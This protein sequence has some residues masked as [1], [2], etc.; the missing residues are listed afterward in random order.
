[1]LK[2]LS[3][4]KLNQGLP[5]QRLQLCPFINCY[6]QKYRVKLVSNRRDLS[7]PLCVVLKNFSGYIILC[8]WTDIFHSSES[9][10][11]WNLFISQVLSCYFNVEHSLSSAATVSTAHL[12]P[13]SNLYW[14]LAWG[15]NPFPGSLTGKATLNQLINTT[16]FTEYR[17]LCSKNPLS[18]ARDIKAWMSVSSWWFHLSFFKYLS[19]NLSNCS[20]QWFHFAIT[21]RSFGFG[22]TK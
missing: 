4:W 1:M 21:S 15:H 6:Q 20:R 3:K 5:K 19:Y 2:S 8:R 17:W 7:V 13:Y 11:F 16:L 9:E 18:T 10:I 22:P 14:V 12:S